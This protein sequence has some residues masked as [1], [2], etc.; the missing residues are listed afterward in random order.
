MFLWGKKIEKALEEHD[1]GNRIYV[2][3]DLNEKHWE[4]TM[5]DF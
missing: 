5:R 1:E 4:K 3:K 2:T